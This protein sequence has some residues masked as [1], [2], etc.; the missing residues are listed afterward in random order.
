MEAEFY[1]REL[2]NG[3][4]ILV[5][6][7]QLPLFSCVLAVRAGAA[8]EPEE[9][10]GV[11]HYLEHCLFQGTETRSSEEL[12]AAVEKKGGTL[13]GFTAEELTAFWMKL[14]SQY[15]DLGLELLGDMLFHPAF[16]PERL[17]K[18]KKVVL[19]EVKMVHDNPK[20]HVLGKIKSLLYEKP[21]GVE[22]LGT[23]KTVRRLSQVSLR[24]FLE[25]YN[26]P[27]LSVVGKVDPEE[28]VE[29]AERYLPFPKREEPDIRVRERKGERV[30]RR[31][32]L[33]QA[34]VALG[35]H[36]PTLRDRRRYALQS[37]LAVLADGASSR[38]FQEI[39]DK[40]GLAYEVS[41]HLNVGRN[42]G[43]VALYAGTEAGKVEEVRDLMLSEIK[44]MCELERKELEEAKEQ[45]IGQ[46]R[47]MMENSYRVALAL[48]Y[49]ELAGSAEEFYR[50]EERISEVKLEEV[51]ELG[52]LK[53]YS[54]YLL[55]PEAGG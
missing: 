6:R 35:F 44:G 30:E 36:T 8:H 48:V 13:N 18:E 4:T 28:V 39:R 7:R 54:L 26:R 37:F 23:V 42:Y 41:A 45:L 21:F 25:K 29:L 9:E 55:L 16:H 27:I 38:L 2:E 17:E 14:P 22:V 53:D 33:K 12:S 50:Y 15:L 49:E 24:N 46:H 34:H 43:Y 11:A 47:L 19:E 31:E 1:R 5:E 52:R 20:S 10:K 32:E 51:R 40:R 3:M